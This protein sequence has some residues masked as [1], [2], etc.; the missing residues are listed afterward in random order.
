MLQV[1]DQ[2]YRPGKG[3]T[4]IGEVTARFPYAEGGLYMVVDAQGVKY[5]LLEDEVKPLGKP[6]ESGAEHV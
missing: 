6:G 4:I 1:G 3:H 5:L 2:V